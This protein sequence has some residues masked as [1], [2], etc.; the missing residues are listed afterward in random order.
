NDEGDEQLALGL[1]RRG[2]L[3]GWLKAM[4]PVAAY[5]RVKFGIYCS[6]VPPVLMILGAANPVCSYSAP[7]SLGKTVTLRI[8]G[9]VW[10]NPDEPPP[11]TVVPT[12]DPTPVWRER[13]PGTMAN[14][15]L[16]L[17]DTM[18]ARHRQD[19]QQAIFDLA[20]GRGR[21][22]GSPKGLARQNS[23]QTA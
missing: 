16:V 19:V 23:W 20:Q 12:W 4:K 14:I 8:C 7:T 13:A 3:E 6:F 10:G 21:G 2:N 22:R 5:P 15:P 18:R 11:H 17:D 1:S 9:S